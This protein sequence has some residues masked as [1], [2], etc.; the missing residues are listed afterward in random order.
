MAKKR[1][2]VGR[3]PARAK[4]ERDELGR[5]VTV[6]DETLL[7]KLCV[8]HA[9]GD[10]RNVTAVRCQVHP[11]ML[12]RWLAQGAASDTECIYSRLFIE[13]GKIEGEIRAEII[14][15][16]RNTQTSFEETSY[17]DGKPTGKT[18]TTRRTSGIQWYAERRFRQFRADWVPKEDEGEIVEFLQPKS[19]AL[20]LEQAAAIVTQL[21]ENMPPALQA[22]FESKGWRRLETSHAT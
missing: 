17:D 16:T 7:G 10:F 19:G 14:A 18:V 4:T 2:K 20:T 5:L 9:E 11:K 22:I 12:S 3:S 6:L 8:T 1:S 21:A 13:F 15:E